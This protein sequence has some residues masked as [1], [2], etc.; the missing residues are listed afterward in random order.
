MGLKKIKQWARGLK[1][2]LSLLY[3]VYTHKGTPWYAKVMIGITIAY[4]MSPIDL[5]PDFIPV[6]GYLDDLIL[7]P[8][9]I[10][11]SF[12]LVPHDVLEECKKL[13]ETSDEMKSKGKYGALIIALIW[14]VILYFIVRAIVNR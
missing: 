13:E 9:G 4:A 7:I 8:A 10:A 3:R 14:I 11:L 1:K 5:I 2:Q 6:L 12:K